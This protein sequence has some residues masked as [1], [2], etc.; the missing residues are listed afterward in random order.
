[1]L[2]DHRTRLDPWSRGHTVRAE[3]RG[4]VEGEEDT[5]EPQALE[6]YMQVGTVKRR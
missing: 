2:Q 1:M 5:M 6:P 4:N 3:Q